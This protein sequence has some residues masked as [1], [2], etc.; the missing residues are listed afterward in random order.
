MRINELMQI[1][2]QIRK[3]RIEKGLTQK[4]MAKLIGI[5]Y[6]TYSNYEN[7]NR[8]PSLE[9]LR[10]IAD[11]LEIDTA[12]LMNVAPLLNVRD[13]GSLLETLAPKETTPT[14]NIQENKLLS[15]FR[16]LNRF[17]QMEAVKRIEELTEIPRYTAPDRS[18]KIAQP[19]AAHAI[20]GAPEDDQQ[21][22]NDIMDDKNF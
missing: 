3:Y 7:N 2:N 14:K 15:D 22:D 12:M 5:P 18:R 17:G 6:S 19:N 1:G 9:Q 20:P 13:D 21:H 11:A 10:K 8:E 16:Q 4:E